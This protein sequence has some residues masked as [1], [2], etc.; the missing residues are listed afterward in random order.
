METNIQKKGLQ[1]IYGGLEM[2]NEAKYESMSTLAEVSIILNDSTIKEKYQIDDNVN[3]LFGAL[4]F[5]LKDLD[6]ESVK[7]ITDFINDN[8]SE[9]TSDSLNVDY[10]TK[11]EQTFNKLIESQERINE[12]QSELLKQQEL[13]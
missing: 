4:H 3:R 5:L 2:L 1:S 9:S 8:E 7:I 12:L 13:V 11:Y 6:S 10:K